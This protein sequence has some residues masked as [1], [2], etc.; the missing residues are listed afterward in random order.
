MG[1]YKI[2]SLI[3]VLCAAF[4]YINHRFIKWPPTIGI[5]VMSLLTSVLLVISS[6]FFPTIHY[7]AVSLIGSID[8]YTLLMKMML[9]FLLF[10]GGFHLNAQRLAEQK[11]PILTLA[12]I[13]ILISSFLVGGAFYFLFSLFGISIPFIICLLFGSLISPTDPIA[14]LAIL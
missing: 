4:S 12:T 14:V 2:L 9:S 3:I 11:W 13:G 7:Y 1:L 6:N 10:A 8:F 5:M